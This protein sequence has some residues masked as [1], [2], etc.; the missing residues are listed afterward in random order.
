MS[1]TKITTFL[2]R[3]ARL[4]GT[5]TATEEGGQHLNWIE[6]TERVS[7]LAGA[8]R[9]AG[10][11]KGDRVALLANNSA[12][13]MQAMYATSWAGGIVVPLNTRLSTS[14]I[15]YCLNDTTPSI[16]FGE[17][18]FVAAVI[19][20]RKEVPSIREVIDIGGGARSFG[21]LAY[22]ELIANSR[23]V[24]DEN[25]L[26][27]DIF[28]IFFTGG[29]TGMA[30]GAM[31]SHQNMIN[32]TLNLQPAFQFDTDTR[33]LNVSPMFHIAAALNIFGPTMAGGRHFF[34]PK[35]EPEAVLESI[36]RNAINYVAVVPTMLKRLVDCDEFGAYDLSSLKDVF[37][38][39]SPALESEIRSWVKALP[40]VRF[41][42]GYGLTETS[43]T[44]SYLGP[45]RHV[46][47]GPKA[48]KTHT[49][50]Q[51]V[52]SIEVDLFDSAGSPV[53]AGVGEIWVKGGTVSSGY[54]NKPD[55]TAIAFKDGWFRTGDV[56]VLDEDGYLSVVDRIKD[57]II[58]GGENVYS[59]EIEEVLLRH[60]EVVESAVIGVAD[61]KWGER[62]HAVV[63]VGKASA[64]DE[65][66]L[67]AYCR[68]HL[69]AYKCPR[70]V[71]LRQSALPLTSTGKIAKTELKR[72]FRENNL[73]TQPKDPQ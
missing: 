45:D 22:E 40:H 32:N 10:L 59:I 54:W 16:L 11:R 28:G 61:E 65:A 56:G 9:S 57:M 3:A 39:G 44:I 42:Q 1:R 41:H 30:K 18:P 63:R 70:S 49:V 37:Y 66:E 2:K 27:T 8:L 60:P 5:H 71:E 73:A 14:E 23:P 31:L 64:L 50:G 48:G 53:S 29:T 58:S 68:R 51:Q 38:G 34:L 21:G 12:A 13:Y 25:L 55:A 35:F 4:F 26:E 52:F 46:F 62:V 15:I 67:L 19:S 43:P 33:C 36:E 72:Q 7:R 20:A 24:P 17:A 6:F 47:E 69:T